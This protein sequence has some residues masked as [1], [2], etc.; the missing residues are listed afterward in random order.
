MTIPALIKLQENYGKKGLVILGISL[1]DP[2]QFPDRYLLGFKE[3]FKINYMILRVNPKVMQDYFP[4]EAPAIPTMFVVDRK[5]R[6]RDKI[7]GYQPG[8]LEK[9]LD[10]LLK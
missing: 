5:G 4:V 8:A 10:R 7:V 1:D 2:R 3:K 9:S 6:I